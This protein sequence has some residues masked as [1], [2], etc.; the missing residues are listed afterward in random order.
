MALFDISHMT[1]NWCFVRSSYTYLHVCLY[2]VLFPR[3]EHL[4]M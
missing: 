2:V 3:Y 1:F 4:F